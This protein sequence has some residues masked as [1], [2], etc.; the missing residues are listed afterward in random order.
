MTIEAAESNDLDAIQTLLAA[1]DLPHEDLTPGHLQ[2]FLVAHAGEALRGVI[3]L[4]P[5]GDGALLRSLAV[6]PE[7]RG[8]GLGTRLVD[9]IEQ[10]ARREDVRT[11]YLLTTTAVGYFAARGYE[12]IERSTLPPSIQ[13]TEEAR[14]LC[15]DSATP[16]QKP[17]RAVDEEN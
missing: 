7:A 15:P 2:H 5:R 8:T 14:C 4:E 6:A 11:I 9:A 13:E 16:M 17:I 3:G 1:C 10:R 12:A